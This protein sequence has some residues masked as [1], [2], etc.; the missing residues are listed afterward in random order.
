MPSRGGPGA[1]IR[2]VRAPITRPIRRHTTAD[3][4][5]GAAAYRANTSWPEIQ[6]CS[7]CETGHSMKPSH[8][9][10]APRGATSTSGSPPDALPAVPV[11]PRRPFSLPTAGRLP[12]PA[13]ERD[14]HH[15]PSERASHASRS[16]SRAATRTPHD[17]RWWRVVLSRATAWRQSPA[18]RRTGCMPCRLRSGSAR[19]C[20][21]PCGRSGSGRP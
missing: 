13:A 7:I 15:S 11:S 10:P 3:S 4:N 5:P 8:P 1:P 19:A 17:R 12:A 16:T 2:T 6:P 9:P 21:P 18:L 20:L 14:P